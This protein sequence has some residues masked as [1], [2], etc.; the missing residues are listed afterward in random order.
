VA[1]DQLKDGKPVLVA[2][3]S[4]AVDQARPNRELGDGCRYERKARGENG[5]VLST[6]LPIPICRSASGSGRP[7]ALSFRYAIIS[8]DNCMY[9]GL[10]L[11]KFSIMSYP[12]SAVTSLGIQLARNNA[13]LKTTYPHPA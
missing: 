2:N 11:K 6:A 10:S 12:W 9:F 8:A 1:A 4:F 3:D 7:G 13:C 5:E